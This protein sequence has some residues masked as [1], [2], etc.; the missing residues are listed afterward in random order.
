MKQVYLIHEGH[1]CLLL[2]FAGWAADATPFRSYRPEGMDY[3]IVYDYR[4]LD[5]DLS[6]LDRYQAVHVLGWSMGVWAAA[7]VL[8]SL[9]RQQRRCIASTTA[10]GGTTRP[11][12]NREG[13]PE[14]LFEG[15]LNGLTPV[16]LQK[17][18]RR[19]CG[20]SAAYKAFMQVT[21]RRDFEEIRE[22][23]R[24]IRVYYEAERTEAEAGGLSL[25][26]RTYD[27]AYIGSRDAIFPPEN[28][29]AHFT[30]AGCP[31][32][33]TVDCAHYDEPL[34]RYLLEERWK[35]TH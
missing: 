31:E 27:R 5:F 21:P 25:P 29:T 23:L 15:T 12:D 18:L 2:F 24:L 13:I 22:E 14:A 10:C 9:S 7:R 8:S 17:F 3:M 16:T 33:R 19:M 4:S 32:V 28:M 34:F 1:P 11:I 30:E 35:A 20:S 6:A 26:G